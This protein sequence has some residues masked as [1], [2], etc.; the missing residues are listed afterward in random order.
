MQGSQFSELWSYPDLE[1][2]LFRPS[3]SALYI[4]TEVYIPQVVLLFEHY[5]LGNGALKLFDLEILGFL[6]L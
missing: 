5:D 3:L 6:L 2:H 1:I 4:Q